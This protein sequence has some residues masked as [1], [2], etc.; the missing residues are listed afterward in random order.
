MKNEKVS[1]ELKELIH[2]NFKEEF[3]IVEEGDI[4]SNDD[5]EGEVE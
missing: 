3:G 4:V 2:K 1:E 5:L